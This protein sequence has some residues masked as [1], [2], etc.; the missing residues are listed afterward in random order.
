MTK[1][2]VG[3]IYQVKHKDKGTFSIFVRFTDTIFTTGKVIKGKAKASEEK[4]DKNVGDQITVQN[5]FCE[6]ERTE[7]IL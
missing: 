7:P 3:S 5:S 4:N 2:L 6:F 1:L